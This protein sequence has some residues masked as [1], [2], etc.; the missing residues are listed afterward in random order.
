MNE[1]RGGQIFQLSVRISVQ[2]RDNQ[3]GI[4]PIVLAGG[5]GRNREVLDVGHS[6]AH[7]QHGDTRHKEHEDNGDEPRRLVME[8]LE[9]SMGL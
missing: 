1:H 9:R 2:N 7:R 8:F 3:P 6:Q 5:H 4:V